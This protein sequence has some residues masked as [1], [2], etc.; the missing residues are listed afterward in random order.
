MAKKDTQLGDSIEIP[1]LCSCHC[2]IP[3]PHPH[4]LTS[5]TSFWEGGALAIAEA[6]VL[7]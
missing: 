7:L 2:A 3:L 6:Q 4:S 5:P 1:T